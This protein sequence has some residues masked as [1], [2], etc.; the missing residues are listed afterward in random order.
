MYKKIAVAACMIMSA[1]VASTFSFGFFMDPVTSDLGF[2]RGTFSLYFSIITVVGAFSLPVYGKVIDRLG[3]R[4]VVIV[5]GLWAGLTIAALSLC[6]S[7]PSFYVVAVLIGLGY[8]GSTFCAAPVIVD[9]WFVEK[10]GAVMG[11]AA[12]CGGMFG[13]LSGLFFPSVISAFGWRVAYIFLGAFVGLFTVVPGIFLLRSKPEEVGLKPYGFDLNAAME[14]ETL[15]C[16]DQKG[17]T[18]GQALRSLRFW[19]L[20]LGFVIFAGTIIVTQHL[21]AY[22]VGIGMTPELAGV[23]MS[24][25]SA[26]VVITSVVV[27]GFLEKVGAIKSIIVCSLLYALSFALLPLCGTAVV[28]LSIVLFVLSL[29]N[30]YNSIF[31][32]IVTSSVFGAKDYASIWGMVSMACVLGQAIGAPLWGLSYDLTGG[33]QMGMYLAALLNFVGMFLLVIPLKMPSKAT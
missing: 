27:G 31:A 23:M 15:D 17:M 18:Q 8:F 19:M 13:V 3:S 14:K 16:S 24:V 7:L 30:A 5:G 29:G 25:L 22:F 20:V 11:A 32:P 2:S 10:N 26:G 6:S 33:Y 9:T 1:L 28:P 21:S 4:K 12:A